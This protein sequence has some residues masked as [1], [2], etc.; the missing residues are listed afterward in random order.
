DRV[1][2]KEGSFSPAHG[3]V[4]LYSFTLIELLVVIAIIAILAAM[5]LPAL[6]QA[7]AR[8]MAADCTGRLKQIGVAVTAYSNDNQ[9]YFPG[10]TD[11]IA[12]FFREM[13]PY[14]GN[15][16]SKYDLNSHKVYLCPA[17]Y[18]RINNQKTSA[19]YKFSYAQNNNMIHLDPGN[20]DANYYTNYNG[21]WGKVTKIPQ[22]GSKL[23]MA[24]GYHPSS[25]PIGLNYS[26]FPFK[27]N[28]LP[29]E[30]GVEFRH[31]GSANGL[32][33][34]FHVSSARFHQWKHQRQLVSPCK[35]IW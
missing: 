20:Y 35:E 2:G 25:W 33:A 6:Q 29:T 4:K 28:S 9:E 24:D 32:W 14:I 16:T 12:P 22:P 1:Y 7:R 21:N 26:S 34:D 15:T 19:D 13:S 8:G 30:T 10:R 11:S 18:L 5:L 23:Y 27:E 17:D 3:Q 31:N